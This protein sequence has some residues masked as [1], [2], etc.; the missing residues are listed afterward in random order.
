ML[1]WSA[2][3]IAY[4][5]Y[6]GYLTWRHPLRYVRYS[7]KYLFARFSPVSDKFII[8]SGKIGSIVF[9]VL[10]GALFFPILYLLIIGMK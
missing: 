5:L 8:A 6:T 7:R 2:I 4:S 3:A 1:G 9:L 10:Y